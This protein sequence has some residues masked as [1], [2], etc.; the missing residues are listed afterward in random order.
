[1]EAPLLRQD[2]VSAPAEQALDS[3]PTTPESPLPETLGVRTFTQG[4]VNGLQLLIAYEPYDL[5]EG[6]LA[7]VEW[8]IVDTDAGFTHPA[9]YDASGNAI[10]PFT[11]GQTVRAR[12][13]VT[14]AS[15]TRTGSVRQLTLL[16][17]PV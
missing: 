17:L 3:V 1:M 12:T 8:M 5:E 16:A 7:R 13:S 9:P 14:N 15:G 6:D 4:G 2:R 10:G 11:I